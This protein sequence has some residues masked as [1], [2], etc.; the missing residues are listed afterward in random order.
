MVFCS[1]V[2]SEFKQL[3]VV[4]CKQHLKSKEAG[5]QQLKKSFKTKKKED[6]SK[7]IRIYAGGEKN[8]STKML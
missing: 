6:V 8:Y 1:L 5:R 4:N 2:F 3:S 7:R